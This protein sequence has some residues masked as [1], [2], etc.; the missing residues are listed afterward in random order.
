MAST[1]TDPRPSIHLRPRTVHVPKQYTMGQRIK[2]VFL[3]GIFVSVVI[4]GTS[5][6]KLG[7]YLAYPFTRRHTFEAQ[8]RATL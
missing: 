5:I 1:A 4:I 8:W 6:C 7:S 2:G 3:G